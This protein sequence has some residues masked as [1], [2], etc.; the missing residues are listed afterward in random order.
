M[1][2]TYLKR[3][4][5]SMLLVLSMLFSM[6]MAVSPLSQANAGVL[7][8]V[9]SIAKTLLIKAGS[10]AG[11]AM[12]GVLG[13]AIGGG[14]LGMAVG[15]VAGYFVSKKVLNWSTSSVANFATIAG[16]VGGGLLCA[17][18]GFPMLAIGI[19]GGGIVSRLL[20]K[21]VSALVNK[22]TSKKDSKDSSSNYES[23]GSEI[24]YYLSTINNKYDKAKADL[25]PTSTTTSNII[26]DSQTAYSKYIAAYDKY[27]SCAQKGDQTG[28][29]AAYQDYKTNLELYQSLLKA[30]K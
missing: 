17:G 19:L 12:G 30:G 22:I 14:P 10:L 23:D 7:S 2:T 3:R 9:G 16:A 8:F 20:V 25:E 28:A 6:W 27:I 13:A 18:M 15:A 5:I 26:Q 21:G 11:G 1:T 29:K 4:N 24:D